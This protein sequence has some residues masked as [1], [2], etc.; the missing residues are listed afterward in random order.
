M[1]ARKDS[2]KRCDWA[3]GGDERYIAYHDQEWGVPVT[4]DAKQFEFLV[5]ESAQAGLSWSTVL[6]RRDGYRRA[7]AGYDVGK[8]ARFSDKQVEK[9]LQD[10]GIIRNRMKVQSAVN[11]ARRFMEVQDEFGSFCDYIWGFVG[12]KP[13]QNRWKS[14]ADV[15][16][17]SGESDALAKDMKKR[18]FKFIGSTIMYAHLQATGLVNDH[19]VRCFRHAECKRLAKHLAGASA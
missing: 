12:G 13:I 4:D 17:T 9:L 3:Y 16:A 7:F 2:T 19:L 8:V 6:Y 5:L 15:P 11:N 1:K 14:D 18:G 10:T